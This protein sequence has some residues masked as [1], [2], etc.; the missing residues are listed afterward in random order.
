MRKRRLDCKT[1]LCILVDMTLAMVKRLSGALKLTCAPCMVLLSCSRIIAGLYGH[2][3]GFGLLGR[4]D[5]G[6]GG[7]GG[8]LGEVLH[9]VLC[10]IAQ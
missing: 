9:T 4:S 5:G 3:A 2:L 10:V 6:G 8:K 7:G 1:R